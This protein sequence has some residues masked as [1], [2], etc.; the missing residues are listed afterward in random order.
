MVHP[1]TLDPVCNR[2]KVTFE[3]SRNP[4]SI[5]VCCLQMTGVFVIFSLVGGGFLEKKPILE[6]NVLKQ[7]YLEP[8]TSV[9][10][11]LEITMSIHLKHWLFR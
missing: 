9:N 11:W 6:L 2:V 5:F 4:H 7:Q 10:K 3:A 1:I 8:E